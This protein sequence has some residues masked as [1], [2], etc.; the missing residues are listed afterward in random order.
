MV[1]PQIADIE[2]GGAMIKVSDF[3]FPA[4][5]TEVTDIRRDV[6]REGWVRICGDVTTYSGQPMSDARVD[7]MLVGS[8]RWRWFNP[9]SPL[10]H[11]STKT[12]ASGNFTIDIPA[13]ILEQPLNDNIPF[14]DFTANITVISGTT[15]TAKTSRSFTLGK[16]YTFTVMTDAIVNA[17]E[18][19]SVTVNA[20]DANWAK[21]DIAFKWRI[22]GKNGSSGLLEGS[23]NTAAPLEADIRTLPADEYVLEVAPCDSALADTCTSLPFMVF[24]IKRNAMPENVKGF[25]LPE[26][27]IYAQGKSAK[28]TVGT[29]SDKLYLYSLIAEDNTLMPVKL[30]ELKKGFSTIALTLPPDKERCAIVLISVVN[31]EIFSQTINIRRPA[32]E[33]TK[34][35]AER[36]RERLTPQSGEVWRL[37]LSTGTKPISD[38]GMIATM[39]NHA[40]D[41]LDKGIFDWPDKFRLSP[42][43]NVITL[44]I[45]S[46]LPN[47]DDCR[48]GKDTY[49]SENEE[50]F[51][52]PAFR[53]L[54]IPP[55]PKDSKRWFISFESSIE[56]SLTQYEARILKSDN[57]GSVVAACGSPY[58]NNRELYV[59][60]FPRFTDEEINVALEG[61]PYFTPEIDYHGCKVLQAFWKPA[62]VSDD[63][64][65]VDI[66]FT[67]PDANTA[68]Q[69]MVF[70]W[71]KSMQAASL[72]K[73]VVIPV[74]QPSAGVE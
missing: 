70:G 74:P 5:K 34:I 35:I 38:G 56:P 69:F 53:F 23:G 33:R 51:R 68:W 17:D 48:P 4:I 72:E 44:S 52:C 37:R 59:S 67:V 58:K 19:L 25:L 32:A 49:E 42:D 28:I 73:E 20:F 63:E 43:K 62:L 24:S 1:T 21:H 8:V 66:V 47:K 26:H 36:F 60:N 13:E 6:P 22:T 9:Q 29:N 64:G 16:S 27:S 12:D 39:Y 71:S 57:E 14:N 55:S 7:L 2:L 61:R 18:P 30:H 54:S 3:K 10:G 46:L 50:D 15:E 11:F 65:N 40:L 31:G 41:A 45:P